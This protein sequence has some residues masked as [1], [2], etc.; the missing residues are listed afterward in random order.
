[1][2]F[3]AALLLTALFSFIAGLYLPWWSIAIAAFIVALMIYQRAGIAFLAAFWGLLLLWSSLSFWIDSE[4]ESILSARIGELLGIGNNSFLLVI[5][6]GAIGG[7][8]AG[9]SAMSGSFL[10]GRK[11]PAVKNQAHH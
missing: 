2:K 9:F 3:L 11:K 10:R 8:V 7:V 1:M 4:N 6:T 5:I